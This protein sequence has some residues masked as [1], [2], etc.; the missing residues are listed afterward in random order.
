MKTWYDRTL[1]IRATVA[2]L[3]FF[4][5]LAVPLIL[6]YAFAGTLAVAA[7]AAALV[8]ALPRPRRVETVVLVLA[9]LYTLEAM[10]KLADQPAVVRAGGVAVLLVAYPLLARLAARVPARRSLPAVALAALLAAGLNPALYP[11]LTG[12]YPR[13]VSPPLT[14]QANIPFFTPIAADLDGDGKAEI[15]AVTSTPRQGAT[16]SPLTSFSFRYQVF[17]REGA[18]FVQAAPA[19][20]DPAARRRLAALMRNEHAAAPALFTAWSGTPGGPPG[21]TF[22]PA[23]EPFSAVAAGADPGRLPFAALG[24]TLRGVEASHERWSAMATRYGNP[25]DQPGLNALASRRD[26]IL[27]AGQADVDGDGRPERLLNNPDRGALIQDS[28]GATIWQAPNDSFRFEGF[29][30]VGSA[31]EDLILAQDKGFLGFDERRYLGGYRLEGSRLVRR[32]KVFVPGIVNPVLADVDGDGRNEVVA[33]LYGTQRLV[34]LAKHDLPVA[35]FTWVAVLAIP[36]AALARRARARSGGRP[37]PAAVTAAAAA[38]LFALAAVGRL[39]SPALFLASGPP[40]A[41][42]DAGAQPD[43]GAARVMSEAVRRME[44]IGRYN[45]QGETLTYVGKRRIPTAFGGAV[46]PDEMR[47]YASIWGNTFEAY[48]RGD[49]LHLGYRRWRRRTVVAPGPSPL[50]DSLAYLPSLAGRA[51]LL[52][53]TEL[54]ERTRCRIYAL[55]PDA[56]AVKELIPV[57]LA[58]APGFWDAG[59][60]PGRFLVKVWVGEK[61]GLIHQVQTIFDVPLAEATGLRQKTIVRFWNFNDPAAAVQVPEGL[62]PDRDRP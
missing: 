2:G 31:G 47:A 22:R 62:P 7:L 37:R 17:R 21:F 28:A 27:V 43:P 38:A 8:Y 56:A 48:R 1:A 10:R 35:A 5:L 55:Y 13:W 4:Q 61:E 11:A 41:P 23:V 40:P 29:G 42:L 12:F 51:A 45:F 9:F 25:V 32:W 6:E 53:G 57:A 18:R 33:A 30:P 20:L 46:A 15:A 59:R 60:V 50:G 39:P 36:A 52:P 58:P 16:D 44:G 54:V 14:G 26:V 3:V 19:A 34:V 49:Q 24:L